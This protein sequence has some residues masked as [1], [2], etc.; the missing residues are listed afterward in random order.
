MAGA[1]TPLPSYFVKLNNYFPSHEM[2]RVEHFQALLVDKPEVYHKSESDDHV[3]MYSV[4][5]SFQA[6]DYVWVNSKTRGKGTGKK[7]LNKLK[8]NGKPIFL[9]VEQPTENEPD[10]FK[11]L[12]FYAREGFKHARALRYVRNTV[13]GQELAMEVLYWTPSGE[14]LTDEQIVHYMREFYVE[15]HKHR[16]AEI[17]GKTLEPSKQVLQQL[18]AD[19]SD[20]LAEQV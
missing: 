1:S 15:I 8:K 5:E 17:Y 14:E 10:S 4:H 11:R 7:L 19:K 6:I 12:K 2:K 20:I 3:L 18:E 9:E 13:D 16:D